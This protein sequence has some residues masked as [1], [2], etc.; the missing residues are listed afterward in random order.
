MSRHET[1]IAD[2]LDATS[3]AIVAANVMGGRRQAAAA[4]AAFLRSF[5][6]GYGDYAPEA[7]DAWSVTPWLKRIADEVEREATNAR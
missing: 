4:V 6:D 3:R 1:T 2:A 5:A 7:D